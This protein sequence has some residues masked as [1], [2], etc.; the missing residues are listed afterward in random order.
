LKKGLENNIHDPEYVRAYVGQILEDGA[1][2]SRW[3]TKQVWIARAFLPA[4]FI[5]GFLGGFYL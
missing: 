4:A 2:L 5:A 3:H 1:F